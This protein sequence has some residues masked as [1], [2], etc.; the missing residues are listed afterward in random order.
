MAKVQIK[1]EK[2]TSFGGIFSIMEQFDA[3]LSSVSTLLHTPFQC[4]KGTDT[5]KK[6]INFLSILGRI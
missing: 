2:L 1:S 3:N 6:T 4:Y 5:G